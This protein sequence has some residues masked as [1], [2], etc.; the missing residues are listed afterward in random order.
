[1]TGSLF[2]FP[3]VFKATK[4]GKI[5]FVCFSNLLPPLNLKSLIKSIKTI[6]ALSFFIHPICS[7]VGECL[8]SPCLIIS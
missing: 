3:Y 5:S 8:L 4:F 1:M 2:F 6:A 7:F